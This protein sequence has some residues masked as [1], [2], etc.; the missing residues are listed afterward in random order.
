MLSAGRQDKVCVSVRAGSAVEA[1]G[2]VRKK[3]M[4]VLSKTGDGK[5]HLDHYSLAAEVRAYR[6]VCVGLLCL[7]ISR[8]DDITHNGHLLMYHA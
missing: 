7:K 3:I 4:G 5:R 1:V 8:H 6:L 2:I